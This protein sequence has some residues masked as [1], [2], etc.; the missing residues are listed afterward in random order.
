MK[1]I[2]IRYTKDFENYHR[3]ANCTSS[4]FHNETIVEDLK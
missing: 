4:Y 3:A 2:T 1:Y